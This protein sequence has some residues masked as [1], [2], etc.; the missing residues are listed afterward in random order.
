MLRAFSGPTLALT[1]FSH[2]EILL[3]ATPCVGYCWKILAESWHEGSKALSTIS[4]DGFDEMGAWVGSPPVVAVLL[5]NRI[6]LAG[7][8]LMAG[9]LE[10]LFF[11]FSAS[12]W[13]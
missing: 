13:A 2:L 9:R 12:S 6:R 10:A 3:L 5:L 8:W 7:G 11:A 1:V 4:C